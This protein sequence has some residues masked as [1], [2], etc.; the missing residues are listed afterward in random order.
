M[1]FRNDKRI[2]QNIFKSI[3][4]QLQQKKLP[5]KDHKAINSIV[6]CQTEEQGYQYLICPEG[7]GDMKRY[8]SCRHR[9]CPV[10]ADKARHDWI[11]AQ[12]ERLLNCSHHHVIFTLPHE[13]ISLWQYNRA[14]FVTHFFK[15]CR[16]TLMMLLADTKFLGATPGILMTLHTW[17]RQLNMHPHIHCLVTSGGLTAEEEWKSVNNDYLLP[18]RV[19]KSLFR[20]KLQAEIKEA[21]HKG[22]L[23]LPPD[24]QASEF[25][26]MHRSLYQKAWSVRIQEQYTHGRGVMLY[27]ARY[28]KGGPINPKQICACDSRQVSFRYLDHRDKKAKV[29]HLAMDEFVRRILWHVPEVGIHTVRHFGLYASQCKG[30]R[31]L[32]HTI[33]GKIKVAGETLRDT[34]QLCCQTC[35]TVMKQIFT[36]YKSRNENSFIREKI[37]GFVQQ[38]VQAD[39]SMA[40]APDG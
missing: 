16:D 39:R 36:V 12:K 3:Y 21:L 37:N 18:V 20:G 32:C 6:A 30:K 8:H 11:E 2:L 15:A 24:L 4:P 23:V 13:Y 38:V 25:C 1:E 33:L 28:V 27:L 19:V 34:L 5:L 29:L 7:H 26:R 40:L 14:W 10:C 9:S 22:D 31:N 35:G 17:G